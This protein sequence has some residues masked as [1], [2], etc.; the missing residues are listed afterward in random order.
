MQHPGNT[1]FDESALTAE[2]PAPARQITEPATPVVSATA[3]ISREQLSLRKRLLH[4]RTLVPLVIVLGFLV[5]TAQKLQINPGQTWAAMRSASPGLFLAAFLIYYLSLPI[6]TLRW[7]LLLRNVGY[8]RKSSPP[9]PHAGI[10]F[11]I[12]FI[13]WFANVVV[14]AKLG[15]VYRAYL[16]GQESGVSAIRTFGTVLAERLLDLIVLLVL[17]LSA[18]LISLHEN[19]P[20]FLR[21]GLYGALALVLV[22]ILGLFLLRTLRSQIRRLVPP[23]WQGAYDHLQEGTLGS[24]QRLHLLLPLTAI[25]WCCEAAR[26]FFIALS[27]HMIAGNLLQV[28]AAA[29]FIALGEALLTIV[30]FTSGGI[31]LVEGGMLAMLTLF[32]S[33]RNLA[34]ASVLLDRS[35]S[36]LSILIIGL[37]VFLAGS[38]RRAGGKKYKGKQAN[39]NA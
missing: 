34:A 14:P 38:A 36:L 21:T 37:I 1:P 32:T 15:D 8:S 2:A 29:M 22:G 9:L 17:F 24:F 12:F 19:L 33:A 25:I 39:Q 3:Q 18:I 26:F 7:R 5:Y 16:L 28:G 11:E 23:R 30:P 10:L 31:G 6:R 27:L 13:S 4:W 35:I 20:A